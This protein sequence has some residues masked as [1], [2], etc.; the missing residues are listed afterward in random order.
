MQTR[1]SADD[2]SEEEFLEDKFSP[3]FSVN[4]IE[5]EILKIL[6]KSFEPVYK[7]ELI[8]YLR[9]K[10]RS[11]EE[12]PESSFYAI[13]DK[14]EKT[15]F[16]KTSPIPG[17]GYKTFL[18]ITS[19]GQEE[20]NSALYWA[21]S[22]IFEGMT[23]ELMERLNTICITNMGCLNEM[24]FG[25]ISPNNPEFL[26]PRMC[27]ICV[28]A[29]DDDLPHRFNILMPYSEDTYVP[30][31]QNIKAVPTSI[32]LKTELL[33][34]MM[35]ILT[36]GIVD[37]KDYISFLNEAKRLVKI[38]GKIAFVEIVVF[39]SYLFDALQKLTNGFDSFIPKKSQKGFVQFTHDKLKSLIESVF[40]EGNVQ[41][42][43]LRE[44]V[45]AI[46]TKKE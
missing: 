17:K 13:F 27:N 10:Y 8:T 23:E 24:E 6:S 38:G 36:L 7:G 19:K 45:L 37:E 16:L 28:S 11:I 18:E 31:Y 44:F 20:L 9:S 4:W 40:G 34:R 22:S 3:V 46:A 25:I 39:E 29:K 35:S 32:P 21:I 5:L 26:V 43:D 12:K 1:E 41:L 30:L 15:E 42:I 14:L 2:K 33:D